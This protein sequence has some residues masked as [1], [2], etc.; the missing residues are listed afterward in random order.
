ML[1]WNSTASRAQE[2]SLSLGLGKLP[3]DLDVAVDITFE[4]ITGQG[5]FAGV[6]CRTEVN[7]QNQHSYYQFSLF[8]TQSSE[9]FAVNKVVNDQFSTL[10]SYGFSEPILANQATNRLEAVCSGDHL[11]LLLNHKSLFATT[12]DTLKDGSLYLDVVGSAP[13]AIIDFKNLVVKAP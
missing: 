9:G 12:D 6:Y 4:K 13:G 1:S 7:S 10:A 5:D 2:V 11:Q 3:S 8:D